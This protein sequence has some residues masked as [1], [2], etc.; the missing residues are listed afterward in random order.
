[1][2]NAGPSILV[3]ETTQKRITRMISVAAPAAG[4]TAGLFFAMQN[5]I[6][7]DEFSA[8]E[9]RVYDLKPYIDQKPPTE[10]TPPPP[11]PIRQDPISPPPSPPKLVISV[12]APNVPI[13]TYDG[14]APADYGEAILNSLRPTGIGMIVDRSLLPISPPVPTYPASAIRQ[15]LDGDCDVHLKVSPK[16]DPFDVHA[17]CT[18]PEFEN[19]AKRSI[20]KV[21][22][23]PQIRNGMPVTVTGVVYPLEF[24]LKQ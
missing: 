15:G 23:A 10:P 13:G 9:L 1:M 2:S 3:A 18:H 8:P 16:G 19:A 17:E 12:I 5:L 14:A 24:R 4:I 11:R 6:A 21:R 20:E 22:F 7:E